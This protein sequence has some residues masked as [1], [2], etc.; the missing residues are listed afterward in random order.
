[1]RG[2]LAVEGNHVGPSPYLLDEDALG[3][4]WSSPRRFPDCSTVSVTAYPSPAAAKRAAEST[5]QS[6][7]TTSA[8]R[9]LNVVRYRRADD[10]RRGLLLPVGRQIV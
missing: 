10:R 6:I 1:M 8:S 4:E 7:P 3:P 9:T 5:S 2:R